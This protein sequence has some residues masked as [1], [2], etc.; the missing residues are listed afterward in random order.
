M[1]PDFEFLHDMLAKLDDRLDELTQISIKQQA[2]LEEHQRRS[3]ANE[4]A[5]EIL[6]EDLKPVRKHVTQVEF[7]TKIVAVMASAIL[8]FLTLFKGFFT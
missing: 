5:V 2:I 1:K 3:L 8:F 4:K 6:A 7:L